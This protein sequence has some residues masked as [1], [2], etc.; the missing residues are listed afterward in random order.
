[1]ARDH[2]VGHGRDIAWTLRT[3]AMT[4]LL[5]AGFRSIR[6]GIQAVIHDITALLIMAQ[7]PP[8]DRFTIG[9]K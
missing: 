5:L 4:L 1:V 6:T 2:Q 8:T 3:A 7:H 9:I